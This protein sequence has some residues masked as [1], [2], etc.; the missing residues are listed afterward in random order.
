MC[1]VPPCC[2]KVSVA[3][4][5]KRKYRYRHAQGKLV[6]PLPAKRGHMRMTH[7]PFD[8]TKHHKIQSECLG[9]FN[10]Q[11]IVTGRATPA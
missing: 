1:S 6:E 7:S 10:L 3:Q 11:L 9:F 8:R 4:T 2:F 5:A